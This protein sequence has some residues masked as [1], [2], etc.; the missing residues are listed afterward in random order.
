MNI[1]NL[2]K[3]LNV[4]SSVTDEEISK[5][6]KKLAFQYHPDKN[7]HRI[8]WATKAMAELNHAYTTV[9][10]YRFKTLTNL[11]N[12]N[13][14]FQEKKTTTSKK[15]TKR[16][17]SPDRPDP[18]KDRS[19]AD[20][21]LLIN[22]FVKIREVTKDSLYQY[23]QYKLYNTAIRD[24]SGNSSRFSRIVLILRRSYH[25]INSLQGKTKDNELI[26]HF[27]IFNN[28]IF[29]FYQAS[30]CLDRIDNYG[31]Q[32]EVD[33][34]RLYR[35]G[36]EALNLSHKELFFDRHNRGSFN[37]SIVIENLLSAE[38]IFKR[39]VKFYSKTSWA[40]EIKIKLNYTE[41]LK[42]YIELFF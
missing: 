15:T 19:E 34:Y 14:N 18:Y 42:K 27:T 20:K 36:D 11:S 30:E 10:S 25:K 5:S 29:N 1:D 24:S 23:F 4:T 28:M 13:N 16:K 35:R 40:V 31:N 17:V 32:I 8:E 41:A 12:D 33:A 26:E 3:I 37:S 6:Y 7:R 38:Y 22:K 21:E 9:T 2:Y 39:A